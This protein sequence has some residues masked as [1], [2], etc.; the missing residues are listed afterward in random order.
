[1]SDNQ[2]GN[3]NLVKNFLLLILDAVLQVYYFRKML[4]SKPNMIKSIK[5]QIIVKLLH[6]KKKATIRWSKTSNKICGCAE[7]FQ[8]QPRTD[9]KTK[10]DVWSFGQI[11]RNEPGH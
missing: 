7:K 6:L 11:L 2:D 10:S 9:A 5:T 1:M 8:V 4:G 3:S